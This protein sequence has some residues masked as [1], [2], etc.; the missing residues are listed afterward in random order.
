VIT[1]P[2]DDDVWAFA[3]VADIAAI[4]NATSVNFIAFS[5]FEAT[6]GLSL[7]PTISDLLYK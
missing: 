6:N 3:A 7:V 4:S 2:A 5:P 1:W